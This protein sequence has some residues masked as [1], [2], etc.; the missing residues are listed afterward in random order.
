MNREGFNFLLQDF[1]DFCPHFVPELERI[2][3]NTKWGELPAAINN[4]RCENRLKC[5]KIAEYLTKLRRKDEAKNDN[6]D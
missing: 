2:P 4:V 6:L 5:A 3:L 1:C